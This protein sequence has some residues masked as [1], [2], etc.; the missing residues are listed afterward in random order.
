[1][2]NRELAERVVKV[3]KCVCSQIPAGLAKMAGTSLDQD[4][5]RP[6]LQGPTLLGRV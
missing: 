6:V 1:M 5:N 2:I 4:A 3:A